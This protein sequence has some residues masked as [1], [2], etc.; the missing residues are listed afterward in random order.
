MSPTHRW[1][2]TP[3]EAFEALLQGERTIAGRQKTP[4]TVDQL[5]LMP[6]CWA[7]YEESCATY[8]REQET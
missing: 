1:S 3:A 8:P 6:E 2:V 7:H 5:P 4:Q